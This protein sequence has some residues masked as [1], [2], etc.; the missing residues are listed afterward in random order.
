MIR[1]L[2]CTIALATSACATHAR[3]AMPIAPAQ[4]NLC[5]DP[6]FPCARETV[7]RPV[8]VDTN[9]TAPRTTSAQT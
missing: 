4:Y 8:Q 5:A 6:D 9:L 1:L 3:A 7:E 2:V